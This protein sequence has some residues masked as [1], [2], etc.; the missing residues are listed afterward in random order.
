MHVD[1]SIPIGTIVL[2]VGQF[3]AMAVGLFRALAAVE[4]S[5]DLRFNDILL[6][7]NTFKEG[8][9]RDLQGRLTRLEAGADE[10]TKAL[11]ERTHLHA[12]EINALK[13]QV[14]RLERPDRYHRDPKRPEDA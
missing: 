13:L 5:I 10:W 4:R 6:K 3:L 8:D 11:R 9:I 7:L 12:N 14:D 1:W 2:V